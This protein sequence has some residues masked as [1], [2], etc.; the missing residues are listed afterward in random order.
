LKEHWPSIDQTKFVPITKETEG[1]KLTENEL[2]WF[3]QNTSEIADFI[4]NAL[5]ETHP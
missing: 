3:E 5:K 2:Q 4:H 1:F